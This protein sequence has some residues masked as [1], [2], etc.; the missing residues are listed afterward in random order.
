LSGGASFHTQYWGFS[1]NGVVKYEVVLGD[2]SVVE[3]TEDENEDLFRALKGGGSNLGIATRFD[4]RTYTVNPEGA[5]GGLIF[6]TW[7]EQQLWTEQFV[8]YAST[9]SGSPDHWFLLYRND[10][11][12]LGIMSMA[13]ST[14]GK[15]N[16]TTFAPFNDFTITRDM[17]AK[18][19]LSSI[20]ASISDTGGSH[21]IPWALTLQP[22]KAIMDKAAEIFVEV[23][24]ALEQAGVPVSVNFV[25]QPLPKHPKGTTVENIMGHDKNLPTDSILFEARITLP[26]EQATLGGIAQHIVGQGIEDLR[27]FSAAQEDHSTFLYMNYAHPEQDVISSY[28][29]DNLEFLKSTAQKYDPE[30]FFQRRVTGGWK[31]S[32][33]N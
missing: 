24:K 8:K 5:Y 15:E 16:S 33:G 12:N 2:G 14:D 1:C 11:G 25:F 10:G 28:G 31:V 21:Y 3:A 20:A 18:Q 23:T 4:L 29:E 22:T 7:P 17:R 27:R 30:G 6:G 26:A 13:V 19:S 32:R 9:S